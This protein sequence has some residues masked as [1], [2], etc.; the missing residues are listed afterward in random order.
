[1]LLNSLPYTCQMKATISEREREIEASIAIREREIAA[2]ELER[3]E[4][5]SQMGV[6]TPALRVDP[7]LAS[8]PVLDYCGKRPRRPITKIPIEQFGNT[9]I[10]LDIANKA[11]C[12]QSQK[13][14]AEIQVL[15]RH[16]REQ[17][18]RYKVAAERQRKIA[19]E[20]SIDPKFISARRSAELTRL[21]ELDT[22]TSI[23]EVEA[24]QRLVEREIRAAKT[25]VEKKG[26]ALVGI[27][28]LVENRRG[29]IDQVD[30][31]YNQIRIVNRDTT[32]E[33]E[34][35]ERAQ[36]EIVHAS[37]WLEDK[38]NPTDSIALKVIEE[39]YQHIK[40]EK[41]QTVHEQRIPQERVIKAQDYRIMQLEQRVRSV[42]KALKNNHLSS[43][44][45]KVVSR[46]WTRNSVEVPEEKEELYD[47]E[48]IIPAQE[49]L[50]PG[51]YNLLLTEK[52]KTSRNVSILTITSQEKEEVIAAL[53]VKLE[54]YAQQ[55][56][57]AIQELDS[58]A[59]QA[60]FAEE[61]QRLQA[62]E[63]VRQ[64]RSYCDNLTSEKTRL[65]SVSRSR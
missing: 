47:I 36:G 9:I 55:C 37:Q 6:T 7:V 35:L 10:Q 25:L 65:D 59:S 32:V 20:A 30:A 42:D 5:Q 2:L 60:A 52:E 38:P 28:K 12:E 8:F 16:I 51:I 50:H 23:A 44:V 58:F 43:Q 19:D 63:W 31:L 57:A 49:K 46:A 18:K 53:T 64:Q 24:R 41:D 27:A 40:G 14:R 15:K 56:N 34:R 54:K 4:L 61:Q 45:E 22:E 39:D 26:Q 33:A 21:Q 11:I 1:M 13:E 17:E 29:T 48:R 62:L 3:N